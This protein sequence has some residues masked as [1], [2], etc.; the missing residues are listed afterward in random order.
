MRP[1][2]A[3][4]KYIDPKWAPLIQTPP[5]PEYLSGHSTISASSATILTHFSEIISNRL[6]LL[7]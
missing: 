4:R 6:I 2:A 3:T 1:E 7:K 5:F